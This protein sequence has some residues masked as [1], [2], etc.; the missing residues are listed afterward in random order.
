MRPRL[1]EAPS[2]SANRKPMHWPAVRVPFSAWVPSNRFDATSPTRRDVQSRPTLF[3]SH[4]NEAPALASSGGFPGVL[5]FDVCCDL[6]NRSRFNLGSEIHRRKR[7]VV[8]STVRF[9]LLPGP[10]RFEGNACALFPALRKPIIISP[11]LSRAKPTRDSLITGST[12]PE[13]K[14]KGF[15]A[16]QPPA[17]V[18]PVPRAD[19]SYGIPSNRL[20]HLATRSVSL[21]SHRSETSNPLRG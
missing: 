20:P 21:H 6:L 2:E 19:P 1:L 14:P 5:S 10:K 8:N 9:E 7:I 11:I 15:T 17:D 13:H 16:R 18:C 4:S 3:Q 12:T